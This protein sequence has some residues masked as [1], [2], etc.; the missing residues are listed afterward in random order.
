MAASGNR[1]AGMLANFAIFLFVSGIGLIA[2]EF[3]SRVLYPL[4]AGSVF[5]DA[6]GQSASVLKSRTLMF[7]DVEFYQVSPD[8][9]AL[10]HTGA[11]GIR[12]PEPTSP[13]NLVFL[14][15]SFTFGQGLTDAQTFPAIYCAK[16]GQSCANLGFPGTGTVRQIAILEYW[17]GEKGWRPRQVNLFVFAMASAPTAGNDLFDNVTEIQAAQGAPNPQEPAP[18]SE[19]ASPSD[20]PLG[21]LVINRQWL[22]VHSNLVRIMVVQIG[23]TLRS[24][25]SLKASPADVQAGIKALTGQLALLDALSRDYEF[26][27]SIFLLH[28]MQDLMRQTY[29]ETADAVRT[30][31]PSAVEVIDTAEAMLE[32]PARFYFPFDG[33]FNPE[34]AQA[35]AQFLIDR[36]TGGAE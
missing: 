33:H 27:Y 30:A 31:A 34:G 5:L 14:G 10:S 20:G 21:W 26:D 32:D 11:M 3:A 16:T 12:E 29:G 17:L 25:F 13:P 2:L 18:E 22:R 23:P 19:V 28:P 1:L 8:F 6:E 9:N 4:P 7:P 15:D 36:E 35:I 24:W